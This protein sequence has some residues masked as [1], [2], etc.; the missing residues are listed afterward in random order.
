MVLLVGGLMLAS[1]SPA[2]GQFG[3]FS[4]TRMR[5]GPVL[6]FGNIG[7]AGASFGGRFEKGIKEL[8]NVGKGLLS[9]EASFDYYSWNYG[10]GN[11]YSWKAIPFSATANYHVNTKS[12]KWGVFLGAGLGYIHWSA[13]C[14]SAACVGSFSSGVYF[15]GR[16]GGS[17]TLAQTV[18]LY[19]DVG[20]G[21]ATINAGVM[22]L[23]GK[24]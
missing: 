24:K 10:A 21:A 4:A 17:Y 20:A 2:M 16:L 1:A 19:A 5:V 11:A 13:S 18:Q 22:F 6:G 3:G 9:I 14:P 15:V 8:P 23:F 12:E 7:S